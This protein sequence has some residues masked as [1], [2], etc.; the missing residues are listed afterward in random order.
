VIAKKDDRPVVR[1]MAQALE[2]A[3]RYGVKRAPGQSLEIEEEGGV[4]DVVLVRRDHLVNLA[5][6]RKVSS[7]LVSQRTVAITFAK[8]FSENNYAPFANC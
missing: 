3:A 6:N 5:K 4:E 8:L 1:Q 2:S 7:K